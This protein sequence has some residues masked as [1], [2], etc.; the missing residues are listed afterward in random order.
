MLRNKIFVC[1]LLF[2]FFATPCWAN[3]GSP[4]PSSDLAIHTYGGGE[5]LEKVFNS[6]SMLIYGNTSSGIDKTFNGILRIVLAV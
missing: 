2:L 1:L 6:I 5:L 4:P 3:N